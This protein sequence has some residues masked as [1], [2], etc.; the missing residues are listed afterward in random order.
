[1]LGLNEKLFP[2]YNERISKSPSIKHHMDW[3]EIKYSYLLKIKFSKIKLIV[4]VIFYR[5]CYYLV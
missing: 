1:M 3:I 4:L 2:E 5:N